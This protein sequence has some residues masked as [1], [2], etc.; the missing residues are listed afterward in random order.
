MNEW[1]GRAAE[2][3]PDPKKVSPQAELQISL[4]YAILNGKAWKVSEADAV[5]LKQSCMTARCRT[6]F[7][8]R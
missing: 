7:A 1:S 5:L 3:E 6:T 2:L 4:I 8:V